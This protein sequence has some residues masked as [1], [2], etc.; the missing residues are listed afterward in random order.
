MGSLVE[1]A[2]KSG[3]CPPSLLSDE[4]ASNEDGFEEAALRTL[5]A[6]GM[7]TC[8]VLIIRSTAAEWCSLTLFLCF[9]DG[10]ISVDVRY[11]GCRKFLFSFTGELQLKIRSAVCTAEE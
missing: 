7:S 3:T 5:D 10:R 6:A 9:F 1:R 2:R 11:D 4:I 8:A